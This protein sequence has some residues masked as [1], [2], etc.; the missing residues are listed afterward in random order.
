VSLLCRNVKP[1]AVR[2]LST[3]AT[4]RDFRKSWWEAKDLDL[5]ADKAVCKIDVPRKGYA[6]GFVELEFDMDG[7]KYYLSTPLRILE[8]KK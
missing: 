6:A 2:Q 8:P 1:T 5:N 7:L 4:T 3:T